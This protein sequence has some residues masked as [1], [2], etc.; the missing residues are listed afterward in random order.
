MRFSLKSLVIALVLPLLAGAAD[1]QEKVQFRSSAP[2]AP[3][4]AQLDGYLFQPDGNGPHPALVFMHGCGGLF[5][6]SGRIERRSASWAKR[7][8]AQGYVVLMVDSFTP[9]GLRA[10]C[11]SKTFDKAV[12]HARP[13]DAYGALAWL[14]AQ[15]FVQADRVGLIGWSQ[16]GGSVLNALDAGGPDRP[17]RLPGPDFGAAVAFY[18]GSCRD[19]AFT[20]PWKTSVPTLILQGE[21]DVWTPAPVCRSFAEGAASRGSPVRFHMYPGAYHDFDWPGRPVRKLTRIRTRNGDTPIVGEDPQAR[22]D[23]LDRVPDFLAKSLK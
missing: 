21:K 18:P 7:L 9:R 12:Y 23:A 5:T 3:T 17:A 10:M 4:D 13:G 6:K 22:A 15:S 20:P 16:G 11:S 19:S 2:S 14:Q 8:T 1:A